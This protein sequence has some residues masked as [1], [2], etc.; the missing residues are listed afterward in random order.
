MTSTPLKHSVYTF[1][2]VIVIE[3]GE[4]ILLECSSP[5]AYNCVYD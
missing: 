2:N 1:N 4:Q 5:A 3:Q